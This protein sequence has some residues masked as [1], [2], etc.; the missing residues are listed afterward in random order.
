LRFKFSKKKLDALY[1]EKKNP[2]TY[3][4]AIIEAFFEV[5]SIIEAAP[6][7]RDLYN[8]KSLHFEKLEGKRGKLEQRSLKLNDQ[9]RLIVKL[10]RDSSGK[11]I[12][13]IDI[14]DYH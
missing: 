1:Y 6:D 2:G 7:E 12:L 10:E 5:M 9:F 11:Y 3:S 4:E 14:E 8:F 13:I